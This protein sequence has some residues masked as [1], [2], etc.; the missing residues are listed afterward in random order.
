MNPY[1]TSNDIE[2]K[3][4]GGIRASE[5]CILAKQKVDDY[6]SKLITTLSSKGKRDPL[7]WENISNFY[8]NINGIDNLLMN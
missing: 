6:S 2:S 3:I 8:G 1:F 5:I 4:Q 7:I